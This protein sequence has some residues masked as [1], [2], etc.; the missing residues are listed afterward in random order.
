MPDGES[1]PAMV[2]QHKLSPQCMLIR[3]AALWNRDGAGRLIAGD[4]NNAIDSLFNALEVLV[5]AGGLYQDNEIAE[6]FASRS[7]PFER[8]D[9]SRR[10][11][12]LQQFPDPSTSSDCDDGSFFVYSNPFIFHPIMVETPEYA[13]NCA[14][15]VLFNL[16]LALHQ[17]GRRANSRSLYR[18]RS[19]YNMSLALVATM[20]CQDACANLS[21]AATN[22]K[23]H[24]HF[25]VSDVGDARSTLHALLNILGTKSSPPPFGETEIEKF[26]MNILHLNGST[27][28][29]AA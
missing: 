4:V 1:S 19:L 20:A 11:Q 13:T 9:S 7:F 23:A 22:N 17:R 29:A 21:V 28:A 18:A 16:A 10:S 24:V 27:L 25:E 12:V 26:Y 6:A 5:H 2:G 3:D 8:E 14:A 15:V